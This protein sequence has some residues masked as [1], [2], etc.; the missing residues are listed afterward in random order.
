MT[1]L[2]PTRT[3]KLVY[4]SPFRQTWTFRSRSNTYAYRGSQRNGRKENHPHT[5]PINNSQQQYH[6]A[7]Y[8]VC[9]TAVATS[10]FMILARVAWLN[11]VT[12]NQFRN[13]GSLGREQL[14]TYVAMVTGTVV[15]KKGCGMLQPNYPVYTSRSIDDQQLSYPKFVSY[16]FQHV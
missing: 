15:W 8:M 5:H 13:Y 3:A 4:L 10:G 11:P 16:L 2:T 7:T 1:M 6:V 12:S 14:A 9:W